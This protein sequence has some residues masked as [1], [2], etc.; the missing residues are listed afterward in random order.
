MSSSAPNPKTPLLPVTSDDHHDH[1]NPHDHDAS[2]ASHTSLHF[3]GDNPHANSNP[4]T[5]SSIAI[6]V[7]YLLVWVSQSEYAQILMSGQNVTGGGYDKP[8]FI[9]YLNH[10]ILIL[11][12]PVVW[13]ASK[14][15]YGSKFNFGDFVQQWS[16]NFSFCKAFYELSLLSVGYF[17]C[18][19][20]W[21]VGLT[22]ISVSAS[23]ALYQLQCVFTV[24]FS[25]WFLGEVL[26]QNKRVG[27]VVS[28]AG[29]IS[30]VL[31]PMLMPSPDSGEGADDD[32]TLPKNE[33]NAA[34]LG[35]LFTI[36]SAVLWGA[37]EVGYMYIS[38]RK[39]IGTK[40]TSS[41]ASKFDTVMETMM[42]LSMIGV[43]TLIFCIPLLALLH[44]SGYE[45]FELPENAEQTTRLFI[46]ATLSFAFDL[47]F[48]LAI[49]LTSPVVVSISAALVIPLSFLADWF[50]NDIPVNMYSLGGSVVVILGL[51][52]LNYD[53]FTYQV[54]RHWKKGRRASVEGIKTLRRR[55]SSNWS[56]QPEK[57]G[58]AP[59]V[60]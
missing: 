35:T 38:D 41:D 18:I 40:I 36:A 60:E 34:L 37:Y 48:A 22:Y 53:E 56:P 30:V 42:T 51:W 9:C 33:P 47:L 23:N 46:N 6:V 25:V 13:V 1:H 58:P 21:V 57:E 59:L 8:G 55:M 32:P 44:Y 28:F 50:L 3:Q 16:G 10:S 14:I 52:I 43:G 7:S 11:F 4:L 49:F 2:R 5:P 20:T 29:I 19:W 54:K 31:P 24:L 26:T 45:P 12:V 15:N 17:V 27:C 39:N